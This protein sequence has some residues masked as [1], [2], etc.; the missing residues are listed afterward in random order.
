MGIAPATAP[1]SVPPAIVVPEAA[2]VPH[3]DATVEDPVWSRAARIASLPLATGPQAAGRSALPTTVRLLWDADALY[4]R[5]DCLGGDAWAPFGDRWGAPHYQGDV[6]EVFLD[7]VG[8]ARQFL[9]L[10]V[11][12]KNGLFSKLYLATAEPVSGSDGTLAADFLRRDQWEVPDWRLDGLRNAAAILPPMEGEAQWRVILRLPAASLLRRRGQAH[13]A[14]GMMLRANFVR[15]DYGTGSPRVLTAMNWAPA[16]WGRPH[17]A[18]AQ[19]GKV[20]LA[21]PAP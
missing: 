12:P 2:T 18:P 14:A 20:T 10:E 15:Y 5:F 17:R 21:A 6:I 9:E 7:P 19:M 4:I 1:S 16:P 8:D 3:L 11:S 13:F